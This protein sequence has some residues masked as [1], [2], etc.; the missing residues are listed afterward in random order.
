MSRTKKKKEKKI[1]GFIRKHSPRL[2]YSRVNIK[3]CFLTPWL[4]LQE[5]HCKCSSHVVLLSVIF[6]GLIHSFAS[7][8]HSLEGY[9][10]HSLLWQFDHNPTFNSRPLGPCHCFPVGY[11]LSLEHW[12]HYWRKYKTGRDPRGFK[13]NILFLWQPETFSCWQR[14]RSWP[15]SRCLPNKYYTYCIANIP[16]VPV[17]GETVYLKTKLILF[18]Q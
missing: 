10:L 6:T 3:A 15:L 16:S 7:R 4:T 17:R 18:D 2:T 12:K 8:H 1:G 14:Q 9:P 5:P 13:I 11:G